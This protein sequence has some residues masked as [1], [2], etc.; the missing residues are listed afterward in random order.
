MGNPLLP[1]IPTFRWHEYAFISFMR[2]RYDCVWAWKEE[3]ERAENGGKAEKEKKKQGTITSTKN[4]SLHSSVIWGAVKVKELLWISKAKQSNEHNN[5]YTNGDKVYYRILVGFYLFLSLSL[6]LC[7]CVCVC[8]W[9]SVISIAL[10]NLT[11]GRAFTRNID[12]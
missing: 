10:N 6:S 4:L 5:T 3:K 8:V 12:R 7:V 11:W 2:I 1:M 9:L